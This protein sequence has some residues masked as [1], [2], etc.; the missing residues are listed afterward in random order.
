M[1]NGSFTVP[2]VDISPYLAEPS[3]ANAVQ[4]AEVAA[5]L[6]RAC[7]EVGFI[8]IVG[9]GVDPSTIGGLAA[10]L[11][12]FFALD[13]DTKDHYR[14]PAGSNRGYTP[15][16]SASLSMSLGI[17]PANMMNDFYEAF[18]I[19][20][21]ANDYPH[22]DLP[23]RTYPRNVWPTEAP[24]FHAAVAR[25]NEAVSVVARAVL[26][27]FA[28]A[29]GVG[30]PFFESVTD[31]SIDTLKMNNYALPEVP[32]DFA[33]ELI[34]MGEHTDFGILTVLWADRVAG[35]QILDKEGT[36]HDVMPDEGAFLVNLGDAMARWTNDQWLSTIHRVNPPIS[37]G[38]VQRRRSVAFFLDGNYDAVI[39]P[40]AT[41]VADGEELY[42]PIT[43]EE[44]I[45]AKLA[46]LELGK[47]PANAGREADR[48]LGA[49]GAGGIQGRPS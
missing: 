15:P 18:T 7:R 14:K 20:R 4:R 17:P 41:L 8:Q 32:V 46:G 25:Y 19:G 34:G 47:K 13:D 35:L 6:D 16:K 37:A 3:E 36:W 40:I 5:Q 28:D 49:Q 22:V 42:P 39:E 1:T 21:E 33:E 48:V 45:N 43:V 31:H 44:N 38:R 9:H 2:T 24:G 11:D 29:L 26:W 23:E 12:E 30:R 27:A 10:A